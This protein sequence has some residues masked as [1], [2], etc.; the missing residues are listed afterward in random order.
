MKTLYDVHPD[1]VAALVNDYPNVTEMM[2][3][4]SSPT[5]MAAALGFTGGGSAVN[6]WLRLTN[7]PGNR[8][9]RFAKMWLEQH[10][11]PPV[12]PVVVAA[13]APVFDA[14]APP[15]TTGGAVLMV[16]CPD[17]MKDRA[18]KLLSVIGCEAV[19]I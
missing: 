6:H 16:I 3:Y 12:A 10:R 18:L 4:F 19:E 1:G 13:T 17:S 11:K 2:R 9:E 15:P 8:T 7:T 5:D 14:P